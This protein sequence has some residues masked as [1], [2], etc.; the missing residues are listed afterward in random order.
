MITLSNTTINIGEQLVKQHAKEKE[1]SRRM[2]LKI[3]SSIRYLA[4]QGLP[5]QGDGDEADANFLQLLKLKGED[6]PEILQWL[7]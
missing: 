1:C 2:L 3:I 6:D 7:K 5:I 4:Q